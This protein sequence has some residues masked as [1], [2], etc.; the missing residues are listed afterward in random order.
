MQNVRALRLTAGG[1]LALVILVSVGTAAEDWTWDEQPGKSLALRR[2]ETVVWQF[3]FGSDEP[4]PFFHPV[5][6]AD[7]RVVTWNRPPDHVWHHGLWFSW[8]YVNGLNYWEPDR[9]TGKPRGSTEWGNV[10]L[11]TNDDRTARIAMDLTYRPRDGNPVMTEKRVVEISAPDADGGYFF[12]WISTFTAGEQDVVLDRT[13]PPGEPG[14]K[15]WGGYA[16]LS[17]RLSKEFASRAAHSTE[18]PIDYGKHNRF[19][20]KSPALD[21]HGLIGGKPIG[22]AVCDHPGNLNHPTP[23]YSIRGNPM[24]FFSPAVICYEPH[25]IK[26]GKSLTLRYRVIVHRDRWDAPRL[27]KAYAEFAREGS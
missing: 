15:A 19:R 5:A 21:Y 16:G 6:L 14:G 23:W 25:T 9:A 13:P 3:N 17:L 2:G 11:T 10:T 26:A 8:K 27:K 22:V 4:K 24:S 1:T 20:G 18:G 12:D 7:G